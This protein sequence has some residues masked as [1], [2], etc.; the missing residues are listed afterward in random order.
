LGKSFL[1]NVGAG[2]PKAFGEK[3]YKQGRKI[4]WGKDSGTELGRGWG[5]AARKSKNYQL[6]DSRCE[7][8]LRK[9]K[10][11]ERASR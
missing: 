11:M 9:K 8:S 5:K 1:E 3:A 4:A 2:A 7:K 6:G 10:Y